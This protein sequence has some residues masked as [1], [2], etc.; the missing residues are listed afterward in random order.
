M[1][2]GHETSLYDLCYDV[3]AFIRSL[4]RRFFV[5]RTGEMD[6]VENYY[7]AAMASRSPGLADSIV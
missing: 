4:G 5:E 3:T 1:A 2:E 7:A 6:G